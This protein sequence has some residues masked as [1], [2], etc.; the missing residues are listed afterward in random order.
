MKTWESESKMYM[1]VILPHCTLPYMV[2]GARY[3]FC[4][5]VFVIFI[6]AHVN[7]VMNDAEYR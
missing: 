3:I 1:V 7:V 6:V 5:A 4:V 2:M